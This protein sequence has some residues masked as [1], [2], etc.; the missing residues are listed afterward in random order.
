MI[1]VS[2]ECSGFCGFSQAAKSNLKLLKCAGC[3]F[4]HPCL[5]AFVKG[6]MI[7]ANVLQGLPIT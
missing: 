2:L 4:V 1:S 7:N 6:Q 5:P 3:R